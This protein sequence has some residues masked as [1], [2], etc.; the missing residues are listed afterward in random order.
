MIILFEQFGYNNTGYLDAN[1]DDLC[2]EIPRKPIVRTVKRHKKDNPTCFC[3]RY[4]EAKEKHHFETFYFI[5]IDWIVENRCAIHVKPKQNKE[6]IEIDYMSMLLEA[7]QEPENFNHLE[8]L[9][10]ID[11][12]RPY[13]GITQ[14]QD[15]LSPF[16]IAQFLQ[17]LRQI[18]RKGLKK[19]YY[20]VSENLNAKV[21]GKVLVDRDIKENK[22]K[23]RLIRTSCQ[24]QEFGA[25]CDEN[26]ILKKAYSFSRRV[27]RQYEKGTDI[28]P[29]QHIIDYIHPAFESVSEDIDMAKVK[30]FKSN[31]LFKEYDYALKLAQLILRRYSYNITLTEQEKI[32]TPPFWIDMSKLFELYIYKKL[33][34]V[35]SNNEVRYHLKAHYQE[36]DFVIRSKEDKYVFVVDA[37]YK[38][39][40]KGHTISVE[41]IRQVSGYARI[42]KVYDELGIADYDKNIKCLIIYPRQDGAKSFNETSFSLKEGGMEEKNMEEEKGYVNLFKIGIRLP[43]I[44]QSKNLNLN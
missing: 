34:A 10:E 21:K 29:L 32:A 39:K 36:L 16:L 22:V 33:R 44:E 3:I 5:G 37:K 40:Y 28:K 19:S 26:K 8:G 1:Y 20:T 11:F 43:E 13:I 12:N 35:F 27:I 6:G 17:L 14:K 4:D 15:L 31:P 9:C 23:G 18:V 7:L 42:K 2:A 25:N 30:L 41:D 24:F 38:P